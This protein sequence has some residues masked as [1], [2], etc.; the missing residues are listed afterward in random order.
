M[1][2]ASRSLKLSFATLGILFAG[3]PSILWAQKTDT[4][5]DVGITE[6]K[7]ND[8]L[9]T[10][11]RITVEPGVVIDQGSLWIQDGKIVAVGTTLR[12]NEG[13]RVIDLKGKSIYPGMIDAGLET[14][15]PEFAAN[16]GSPH[17]N[18][19]II[20]QRSVANS[21]ETL[22]NLQRLRRAGITTAL[23]APKDGILKG[24]SAVAMT[25]EAPL[26]SNLI[27]SD[28]AMHVRLTVSRTGGG[29][30]NN[31]PSSPMGAVALARQTFLDTQWY[32]SALRAHLA[33]PDSLKPET[34]DALEA[35]QKHIQSGKPFVFDTLNE[36]YA[37]R[38]D[39]F[40]KEFGLKALLKGT[41]QE[42]QLLEPIAKTGRTIILPVNFPKPPN[43]STLE[44]VLDAELEELM[45]WE[46][47]PE[48][49]AR[50]DRSG[51]P[52]VLTS[53]GLSDPAELIPQVRKAIARG[54]DPIKALAALTTKPAE[55]LGV[56]DQVGKI[57]PGFWANL[58]VTNGDLFAD[59]SRIE[60]V[61]VRGTPPATSFKND[62]DINGLWDIAILDVQSPKNPKP[63][64]EPFQLS[65]KDSTK[66]IAASIL[67]PV[68]PAPPAA[69]P[70]KPAEPVKPAEPAAAT[71]P[72]VAP[73]P[74]AEPA[75]AT[76]PA[77]P[78]EAAAENKPKTET[79]AQP[80]EEKLQATRWAELTLTAS[81]KAKA[82]ATKSPN[83]PAG[84]PAA[85]VP[86]TGESAAMAG[87]AL[88]SM[89]LLAANDAPPALLGSIRLPDG[90]ELI[91]RGTR[92]AS[93]P[94]PS[95]E[96][97]PRNSTKR[98]SALGEPSSESNDSDKDKNKPIHSTLRYPFASLGLESTPE[99]PN[100]IVIQNTT[101]WT[102]GPQG[103]L[104]DAD[105]IVRQGKI[106]AIG[107]DLP[108]PAGAQIIDGSKFEISPG[109]IDC[110][111]HMATDS[112]VNEGTQAVTAE[113][114]IGDF[115]NA[116]DVTLYRQL[117]GGL[118]TANIL[119]GSANPIGGQNQ[120]IK[121]RWGHAYEDL[122][123]QSA[124]A[125]IKFALGEN[126]KQSNWTDVNR[127][128][129][130]Q[131]RMGVEQI[132]RSRFIAAKE[133]DRDWKA[134]SASRKG[135]APRR[136]LELEA[137]AEILRGER[138][139][140]CHSYRQ[141]EILALIRVCDEFGIKIGSLQHILEGYKVADAIA[142]HG[143][144]ASTFSDW[145]AYKLEVYDAIP[146][147]GALMHNQ[148]IVVS[149]NSDDAELGRHM[150]HEAAKAVKYGGL[151]PHS[152]LQFVTLNPAKQ[153]RIDNRVGSL[154]IGKDADFVL[155]NGS[156][157]SVQ[158][159][160]EQTWIDGRKYFDRQLDAQMRIRDGQL[161]RQL[162][163]KVLDS[164][165]TA[166]DRSS[167]A[168]DPSRLWPS[169]DEYCH[170]HHDEN[171]AHEHR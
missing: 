139:I 127:T 125:G 21:V 93:Q 70:A 146:H 159:R 91:I 111:S 115:I 19:E 132:F 155:W 152:A 16:E 147:N 108:V 15:L 39:S 92:S 68:A 84:E 87:T 37:L 56:A 38:A 5:P 24:T 122:K 4:K 90:T 74:P 25:A 77:K 78:A 7:V 32:D 126:V 117:A 9:I 27:R 76:D 98:T 86:A 62:Q 83:A 109:L 160:C 40:A 104:R 46:L 35:I 134:W 75:A 112:G 167:L 1:M 26:A 142:K 123:F 53:S 45:H 161:H 20:P 12:A 51:V 120:V 81:L 23:F 34:N 107:N 80:T 162:V 67:L 135:L 163:Q 73:A 6:N 88:L 48:N 31:Y 119:H 118:T 166:G 60:E 42:Y 145:W 59:D 54:L 106:E 97:K 52:F 14:D 44:A 164:G 137:I 43:V 103:L 3:L 13:L 94:E 136:D 99:Q 69:D 55:V 22:A 8:F 158:A 156:P 41:G 66:K 129:Y 171:E 30:R 50:L 71:D 95:S 121:L 144:T 131:S 33:T 140:H 170:H 165:E 153:L 17:W 148:G 89:A 128:R 18:S 130:P 11:A 157:L 116:E 82:L 2:S 85:G 110:H 149:F 72:A 168:D 150:N 138:W 96:P 36:Q 29:G 151:D 113:V 10:N 58:I 114:R 143:A 100:L 141:D 65:I 133:Y 124:P 28:V 169:H 102:C 63:S 79:K 64:F 105:M 154:E 49:P 47:A 57:R 101:I 61:W